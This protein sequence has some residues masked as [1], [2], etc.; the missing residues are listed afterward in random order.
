MNLNG[1]RA[2]VV[3]D[4]P[5]NIV[6]AIGLLKEYGMEVE[7]ASSGN[8]A[9]QKITIADYDIVFMDYMMPEMDGI[10]TLK[11]MRFVA[12]QKKK[13][14]FSVALSANAISGAKEMFLSNGF[15]GYIPKPIQIH[16]FERVMNRLVEEG[17]T[18]RKEVN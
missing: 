9:I 17:L 6:V 7:T 3:D 11:R 8:E 14:L 1:I 2:L 13:K 18:F 5:M 15:D 16:D 12:D 10:E 4:E